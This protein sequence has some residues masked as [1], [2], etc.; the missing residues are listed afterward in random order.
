VVWDFDVDMLVSIATITVLSPIVV[1]RRAFGDGLDDFGAV[2][3]DS[4]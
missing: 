1:Q 4:V 3:A 2:P